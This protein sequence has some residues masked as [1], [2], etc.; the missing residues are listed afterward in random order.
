MAFNASRWRLQQENDETADIQK[1][2]R[3][4]ADTTY[5]CDLQDIRWRTPAS[6]TSS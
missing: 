3:P 4:Y 1:I 2:Q 5:V 6:I